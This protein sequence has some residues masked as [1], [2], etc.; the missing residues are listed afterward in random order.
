VPTGVSSPSRTTCTSE[1]AAG[2]PAALAAHSARPE[3]RAAT[4]GK[5][6]KRSSSTSTIAP[7][8]AITVSLAKSSKRASRPH[9]ERQSSI[10]RDE[11]RP[12]FSAARDD[13]DRPLRRRPF[14]VVRAPLGH[15][16]EVTPRRASADARAE[17]PPRQRIRDGAARDGEVGVRV[18]QAL[19]R[20]PAPGR[21]H[22]K[23]PFGD[24]GR[25]ED[26]PVQQDRVGEDG[27]A[28]A[29]C[30]GPRSPMAS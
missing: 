19:D 23:H 27:V 25:A 22:R 7:A 12:L 10:R 18:E 4:G 28:D 17:A 9:S 3:I 20:S 13:A 30:V 14:L 21:K 8:S 24:A 5:R 6:A 16:D 26:A 1:A 29:G 2:S 15:A 11:R